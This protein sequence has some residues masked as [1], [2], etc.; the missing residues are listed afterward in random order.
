[1]N[2]SGE[3]LLP[4]WTGYQSINHWPVNVEVQGP[5]TAKKLYQAVE[6][7]PHLESPDPKIRNWVLCLSQFGNTGSSSIVVELHWQSCILRLCVV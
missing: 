1:M 4:A 7:S 6:D 2:I 3:D 5:L